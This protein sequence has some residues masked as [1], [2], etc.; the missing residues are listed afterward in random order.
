VLHFSIGK[1]LRRLQPAFCGFQYSPE[2][3]ILINFPAHRSHGAYPVHHLTRT[4]R[5]QAISASSDSLLAMPHRGDWGLGGISVEIRRILQ[6]IQRIAASN[7]S[8]LIRGESGTGKELI[9]KAIHF[10]SARTTCPFVALNSAS[11][12]EGLVESELFGHERG[13]YTGAITRYQGKV[14]QAHGGTLFLDEIG[15]LPPSSQA[16]LLRVIQER[17]FYRLGGSDVINSDFRLLSATHQDL[18]ALIQAGRF[19]ED[20]Y[21]RLAVFEIDVPPLRH[22][23]DDIAILANQFIADFQIGNNGATKSSLSCRALEALLSYGWPG[24]IRELQNAIQHAVLLCDDGEIEPEHLPERIWSRAGRS[25]RLFNNSGSPKSS[26][27]SAE[28]LEEIE[29][30]ALVEAVDRC[31]GNLSMAMRELQIGRGKLYRKL[32]KYGLLAHVQVK[33]LGA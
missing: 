21:F 12:P 20:L 8:V 31:C 3:A 10:Q 23:K 29:R 17:Q 5:S 9:A 24:N 25:P 33:R 18:G 2:I 14:H 30:K 19:R 11:I 32:K 7:V 28:T 26:G 27:L 4:T 16:K 1:E 6:Q 15:D 22:R 13:A